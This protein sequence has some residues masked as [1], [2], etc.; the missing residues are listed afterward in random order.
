M[1]FFSFWHF[2]VESIKLWTCFVYLPVLWYLVTFLLVH[3]SYYCWSGLIV[4]D[5]RR[6]TVYF[7][8]LVFL[9]RQSVFYALSFFIC[10]CVSNFFPP[11]WIKYN[12]TLLQDKLAYFR[13]KELKDV[14]TQLGLSK[15]G[16]K[17]VLC[18]VAFLFL[19]FCLCFWRS[20]F[21]LIIQ[22]QL[23]PWIDT[24]NIF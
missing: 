20:V 12:C 11:N 3:G 6:E 19:F 1:I 17:Q 23:L 2:W 13:I 5:L 9:F 15:Q 14:L 24:V 4:L 22:Y 16:K 8:K 10:S 21:A 7:L 18:W